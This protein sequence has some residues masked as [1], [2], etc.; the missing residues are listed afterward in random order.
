MT[1]FYLPTHQ[2]NRF[3]YPESTRQLATQRLYELCDPEIIDDPPFMHLNLY[4]PY[5]WNQHDFR[6]DMRGDVNRVIS[7]RIV[8][9]MVAIA[10]RTLPVVFHV[11]DYYERGKRAFAGL[12]HSSSPT[13]SLTVGI[14]YVR[15]IR[16]LFLVEMCTR[17]N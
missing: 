3:P 16:V 15:D 12:Q 11:E 7:F 6:M 2:E 4:P 5:G 1:F 10:A 8:P 13:E 9:R 17:P 14:R